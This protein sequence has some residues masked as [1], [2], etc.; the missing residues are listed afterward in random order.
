MPEF[1]IMQMLNGTDP[2]EWYVDIT[3]KDVETGITIKTGRLPDDG[4]F[5]LNEEDWDKALGSV[6]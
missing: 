4:S 2:N 5:S 6:E 1:G 3:V